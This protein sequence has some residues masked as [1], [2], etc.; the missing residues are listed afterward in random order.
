MREVATPMPADAVNV[1]YDDG[2]EQIEGLDD[3]MREVAFQVGRWAQNLKDSSGSM[4]DRMAWKESDNPISHI[5]RAR[6]EMASND[7]V[8]SSAEFIEGLT[9]QGMRWESGEADAADIWNQMAAE[10]NLDETLRKCGNEL[11]SHSQVVLGMWWD[12]GEFKLRGRTEKGNR[13]KTVKKVY[14]PRKITVLDSSRVLPVGLMAFGQERLAYIATPEEFEA[15]TMM[16]AGGLEDE[17]MARFFVDQYHPTE[18]EKKEFLQW[19]IAVDRLILLND[20]LVRRH[21]LTRSDYERFA[22]VR[23][24]SVFRL[25]DLRQQLM[26]ADRAALIGAANY[27]LLIK[28]GDKDT[29]GTP[30]EIQNLKANYRTL[31]S[32]PVIFSDHRL[33]IEIVTPKQDYTLIAEKYDL[34]D[35]RIVQR[36]LST[37][38]MAQA[39]DSGG[40]M[41]GIVPIGK[42]LARV[43]MGRR[44][45]LGRALE[46][47][48]AREVINHPANDGL[49]FDDAVPSLA[50]TP[51]NITIEDDTALAQQVLSLRTQREISRETVLEFFGFDQEAEAIRRELEELVY[52][53]IFK[54]QVPFSAQGGQPP[55]DQSGRGAEG[56][57]PDGGGQPSKNPTKTDVTDKGT[58]RKATT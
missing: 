52:D 42:P 47:L 22:P 57:R 38:S 15:F 31:A 14:Y 5:K 8:G 18:L 49:D 33:N 24:R 56:G 4:F 2:T 35:R 50:F 37:I 43:L 19:G 3:A 48:L 30:E 25:I 44:R 6:H 12:Y 7:I 27:I 46:V 10:Q 17:I 20:K 39:S 41:S 36:L 54:T 58:T 32:I 34:L 13:R 21:T 40:R 28:K 55:A 9:F 26:E 29:P 23:M 16:R 45:M 1:L 53:A 51:G 11:F